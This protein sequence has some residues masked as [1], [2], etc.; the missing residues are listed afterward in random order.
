[1]KRAVL[2]AIAVVLAGAAQAQMPPARELRFALQGGISAGG[3]ELATAVFADGSTQS[4]R[5]GGLFQFSG[6]VLWQPQSTPV[7][8]QATFGYHA[9][10]VSARNGELRFSR[11]P[12]EFL[13]FYTGVPQWRFGGGVRYVTDPRLKVDVP[14]ENADIRFDDTVGIVGEIGYRLG[15]YA[16]VNLRV[17]AENY[18][19]KS[20]NGVNVTAT[21]RASGNAAGVN[22]V[23]HF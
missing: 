19:V 12:F 14:G 10:S 3:D 15:Y 6:G 17:T 11:Y 13:A 21:E 5:A 4:I 22:V 20:I 16:W 8:L 18:E 23:F 1:M 2:V 9:D 7:A